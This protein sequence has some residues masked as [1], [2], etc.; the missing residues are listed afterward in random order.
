MGSLTSAA[1][2]VASALAAC[3]LEI[4][5][6]GIEP[7]LFASAIIQACL[8]SPSVGVI[9]LAQMPRIALADRPLDIEVAIGCDRGV[10]AASN[11]GI[12]RVISAHAYVTVVAGKMGR[13]S[14][15]ISAHPCSGGWVFRALIRPASWADATSVTVESITLAGCPLFSGSLPATL[16]VGYNHTA[17]TPAGAVLEAAKAGDVAAL[18]VALENGGSTEEGDEVRACG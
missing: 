17:P 13:R 4:P 18:H 5:L 16:R 11:G 2:T 1:A 15:P 10:G 9:E 6:L 7:C 8:N 3:P 12:A 14:A